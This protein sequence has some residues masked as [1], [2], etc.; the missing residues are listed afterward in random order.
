MCP[1]FL[2]A[3]NWGSD[4][5]THSHVFT[6]QH[7]PCTECAAQMA[8]CRRGVI[9]LAPELWSTTEQYVVTTND[10]HCFVCKW[11]HL[12]GTC[13]TKTSVIVNKQHHARNKWQ[14]HQPSM[15]FSSW[16]IFHAAS[17][18]LQH[19]RIIRSTKYPCEESQSRGCGSKWRHNYILLKVYDVTGDE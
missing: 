2:H 18:E 3:E 13:S 5:N 11:R 14:N 1:T 17:N 6:C 8:S 15:Q 4:Y 12:N 10:M 19:R 7:E 9:L 16:S